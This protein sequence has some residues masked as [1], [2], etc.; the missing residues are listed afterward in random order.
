M[1]K[2]IFAVSFRMLCLIV[3]ALLAGCKGSSTPE[4]ET[5]PPAPV[6]AQSAKKMMLGEWTDLFGTT[7]P[8]PNHS[9][10]IS[11]V[12][13]GRVLSV[14]GDGKKP[15]LVEGQEVKPGQ[16]IVQLDDRV[17]R[18]NR[19]KLQATLQDLE[20]QDKQAA[21]AVEL[22]TID[23]NRL[24]ELLQSSPG[25]GPLVSRVD[26]EKAK[27]LKKDAESKLQG[28][29]AKKKAARSDLKAME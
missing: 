5:T 15:S 18:A 26:F 29:A 6:H 28:M 2:P 25:S 1:T 23:V 3:P 16:V 19:D 27:V 12:V 10:R 22:A 11:A 24:K 8:L 17:V 4:E 7:Q 20:E 13:E 9:A 14:L 21:F